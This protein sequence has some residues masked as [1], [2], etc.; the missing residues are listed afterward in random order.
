[1]AATENVR[2]L[3]QSH[4]SLTV[5]HGVLTLFGYGI[6]VRVDG[7]HLLIEDGLGADRR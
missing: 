3:S 7:G 4:N 5:R 2:Q 1:M 6:Q